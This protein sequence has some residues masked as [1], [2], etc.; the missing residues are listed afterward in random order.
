MRPG[1]ARQL[2]G[3][4]LQG[5]AIDYPGKTFSVKTFF[6]HYDD[7]NFGK[8]SNSWSYSPFAEKEVQINPISPSIPPTVSSFSRQEKFP[9]PPSSDSPFPPSSLTFNYRS[10]DFPR[11]PL[12]FLRQSGVNFLLLPPPSAGAHK[13]GKE[14]KTRTNYVSKNWGRNLL[15]YYLVGLHR[16]H[17]PN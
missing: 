6:L 12:F 9:F 7:R 8:M 5:F 10:D 4:K 13:G 11:L 2:A 16:D 15:G 1:K 17:T 14:T 3:G